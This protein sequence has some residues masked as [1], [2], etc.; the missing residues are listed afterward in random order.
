MLI[1]LVQERFRELFLGAALLGRL[2]GERDFLFLVFASPSENPR[3]AD[4]ALILSLVT[5]M[6]KALILNLAHEL[7]LVQG[8]PEALSKRRNEV[9]CKLV[10]ALR[11]I[12]AVQRPQRAQ[13]AEMDKLSALFGLGRLALSA[14]A[15]PHAKP[16]LAVFGSAVNALD[17]RALREQAKLRKGGGGSGGGG[18]K[19]RLALVAPQRSGGGGGGRRC[20]AAAAVAKSV[21]MAIAKRPRGGGARSGTKFSHHELESSGSPPGLAPPTADDLAEADELFAISQADIHQQFDL[22]LDFDAVVTPVT[23]SVASTEG[24]V[25]AASLDWSMLDGS[26]C[27]AAPAHAPE[28]DQFAAILRTLDSVEMSLVL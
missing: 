9:L 14:R 23:L 10:V 26:D 12:P 6:D 2:R 1:I 7:V 8:S 3:N 15:P 24:F 18:A 28:D 5:A 16:N 22:M 4:K 20:A 27:D 19:Q 25:G 13:L 17:G 21:R 11:R